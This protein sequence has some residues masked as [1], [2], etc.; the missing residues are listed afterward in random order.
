MY[1]HFNPGFVPPGVL[2][3]QQS[4]GAMSAPRASPSQS[5]SDSVSRPS[6]TGI[7]GKLP[8]SSA[9]DE[10]A[11]REGGVTIAK[12]DMVSHR[13]Q[14]MIDALCVEMPTIRRPP[15]SK[16]SGFVA[17]GGEVSSAAGQAWGGFLAM[18][19]VSGDIRS[20]I[21][22]ASGATP[23]GSVHD[24]MA[25]AIGSKSWSRAAAPPGSSEE[26]LFRRIA[27]TMENEGSGNPQTTAEAWAVAAP[28]DPLCH[29]LGVGVDGRDVLIALAARCVGM[30]DKFGLA[31]P[32]TGTPLVPPGRAKFDKKQVFVIHGSAKP[33]LI[34][35]P[36]LSNLV[37]ARWCVRAD[38]DALVPSI[39]NADDM[40][41]MPWATLTIFEEVK[42]GAATWDVYNPSDGN[43]KRKTAMFSV[44]IAPRWH[45]EPE[46]IQRMLV[47]ISTTYRTRQLDSKKSEHGEQRRGP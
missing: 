10:V 25:A 19:G 17:A 15:V 11:A 4:F 6:V 32:G 8:H 33:N 29:A 43:H 9:T 30:G 3:N 46:A 45:Y 16:A 20:L 34:T 5:S 41:G 23:T 27:L 22:M 28:G 14:A 35:N 18:G 42:H 2:G 39:K 7:E 1:Q 38:L 44:D 26:D 37:M 31:P 36:G 12:N 21:N 40:I 47:A 13:E 24:L